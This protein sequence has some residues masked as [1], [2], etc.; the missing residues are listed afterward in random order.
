MKN[1]TDQLALTWSLSLSRPLLGLNEWKMKQSLMLF[2][3]FSSSSATTR[4]HGRNGRVEKGNKKVSEW[5][6]VALY[7]PH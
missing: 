4:A 7:F 2:F 5:S 3:P 1:K 6:L